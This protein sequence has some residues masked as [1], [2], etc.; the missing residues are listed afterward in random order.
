LIDGY[1][2]IKSKSITLGAY[3][4]RIAYQ[5]GLA[6]TLPNL[7]QLH[8]AHLQSV[9]FENLDISLGRRIDLRLPFIL[10]KIVNQ[11]RGG[12]C[13]ELNSV[14]AWL[15]REIGFKV[16]LLS[17][18]T[19][20]GKSLSPE[21]DHMLLL[22]G[23]EQPVIADV[24][25]GDSFLLPITLGNPEC[26]QLDRLYRLLNDKKKWVLQQKFETGDWKSQ[27]IFEMDRHPLHHFDAMCHYHQTSQASIFMRKTVCSRAT[28]NGRITYAN[29]RYIEYD[30]VDRIETMVENQASLNNI[31]CNRFG[32]NFAASDLSQLISAQHDHRSNAI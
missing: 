16:D 10:D 28:E 23:T 18:R 31:L 21:F 1:L 6:P 20:D 13:Y 2:T 25:F 27:Y 19:Y 11:G 22:V 17:A 4:D 7:N 8:L 26:F 32:I 5:G 9:P 15:L 12:F 3:L 30:G 14:F 24:G 29:G